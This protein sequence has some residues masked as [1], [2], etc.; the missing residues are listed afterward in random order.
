VVTNQEGKLRLVLNL[1]FLNQYLHKD[2]FKYEDLRVAMLLLNKEDY[3]FKLD[4]KSGYHHL[5]IFEPH[6]TY[7]GFSWELSGKQSY[8]VFKVLPFGLASACYAF[9]KRLRPLVGYW[10]G[11][12]LR[13]ILCLDDGIVAAEN[14][15]KA[16]Q[17]SQKV[18]QDLVNVGLIA[19]EEKSQW[20][21]GQT[22]LWLGFDC[23]LGSFISP[24]QNWQPPVNY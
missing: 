12:G 17:A 21:L 10:R 9:T 2:H 3:L 23:V 8:L 22:L 11:Q 16:R 1:R 13:V 4:L 20:D 24:R 5:D 14:L 7:L 6:Q 19:K 15:D 18:Q